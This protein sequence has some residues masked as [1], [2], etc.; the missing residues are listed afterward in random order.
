MIIVTWCFR[1]FRSL[2]TTERRWMSLSRPMGAV[3]AGIADQSAVI[4]DICAL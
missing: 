4:G 1:I 3:M 2:S